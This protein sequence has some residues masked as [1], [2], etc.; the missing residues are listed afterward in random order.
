MEKYNCIII[1]DEPLGVEILETYIAQIPFLKIIKVCNDA[2]TAINTLKREK[3]D[4]IFLDIH[5]PKISG[6]DFLKTLQSPPKVIITTAYNKYALQGY[7]FNVV[8]YLLKPIEFSRFLLAVNK[9]NLRRNDNEI[10]SETSQSD[11]IYLFFNVNKKKTK[12]FL[13][14]ILYIES[15]KEYIKIYTLTKT[16]VTKIPIS[17][18]ERTLPHEDFLRLHRSFIVSKKK[19][20]AFTANE[21]D[22]GSKQIPIGRS[23]KEYVQVALSAMK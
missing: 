22:I 23:Y 20:D 14:E 17:E 9:L 6:L 2:I 11:R 4:L 3:I 15:Q 13:D 18:I 1:E 5:L 10:I 8:D 16:I 7:E 19:I 21:I 12:I